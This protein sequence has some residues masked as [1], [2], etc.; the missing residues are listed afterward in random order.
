M[1]KYQL[2]TEYFFLK[3]TL[4][5]YVLLVAMKL[6]WKQK[7][8]KVIWEKKSNDF[9]KIFAKKKKNHILTEECKKSQVIKPMLLKR[10]RK[11]GH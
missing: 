6:I 4:I 9:A 2:Y 8:E 7:I 5:M 3:I 11:K 1:S 10:K